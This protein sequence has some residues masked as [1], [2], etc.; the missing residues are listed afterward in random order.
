V[1]TSDCILRI[2]TVFLNR[3]TEGAAAAYTDHATLVAA[4]GR[5][6]NEAIRFLYA[7]ISGTV[8]RIGK[9]NRLSDEDIEELICDAIVILIQKIKNE[10]YR[11]IG[12]DP[13]SFAIEVA[14]NKAKNY[15]RNAMRHA[16]EALEGKEQVEVESDMPQ[17]EAEMIEKLLSELGENCQKLIRL[18]YLEELRDKE[19]IEQKLTQYTTVDALKNYRAKCMKKL[20]EFSQNMFQM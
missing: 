17:F 5:E 19:V 15:R 13:A 20:V 4:L 1:R 16:T 11:Y 12:H 14:K 3:K 9:Q 8:F 7:K 10:S 18:K 2:L 6:K